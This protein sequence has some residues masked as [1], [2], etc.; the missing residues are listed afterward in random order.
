[1]VLNKLPINGITNSIKSLPHMVSRQMYCVYN[2][3]NY[4]KYIFLIFYVDDILLDSND[5]GMLHETKRSITKNFEMKDL[6]ETSFRS[7]SSYHKNYISKVLDRFNM[8][9]SSKLRYT[10]IAMGDK[11]NLKQCP[12]NDLERNKMQK[13]L[14]ASIVGILMYLSDHE[15]QNWKAIKC[16]MHY[17]KRTKEY[18]LTYWI[19]SSTLIPILLGAKIVSSPHLD[20]STCWLEQ[21]SLES[22]L[23]AIDGIKRPLK[24]YCDNNLVILYY[25]NNKSY[26]K[27]KF[28]DIKFLIVK[29]RV[30]NKQI[31]IEHIGTSFMLVDQ[32]TKGL[33]PKV[34]HEHTTHMGVTP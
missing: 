21:L 30:Q 5:I 15:M 24:I 10:S 12:Y 27:S 7:L 19:S 2:N 6:G 17:L 23:R 9:D 13:I 11:F 33:I 25:N 29:Q 26:T 4:S 18:M 28:F 1:M 31:S 32:L 34:F 22:F 16:V 14:Y 3:F 8:K 20:T